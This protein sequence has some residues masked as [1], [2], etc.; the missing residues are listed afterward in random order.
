MFLYH[1]LG[2]CFLIS[3]KEFFYKINIFQWFM[4]LRY[5]VRHL[6]AETEPLSV[7]ISLEVRTFDVEI[8]SAY[9][10]RRQDCRNRIA[11]HR[12]G[13]NFSIS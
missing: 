6:R 3:T 13:L 4:I 8:R 2:V 1:N 11:K 12:Q 10:K 9:A 5:T 7:E